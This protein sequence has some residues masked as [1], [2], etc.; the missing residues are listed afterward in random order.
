MSPLLRDP[1]IQP[2]LQHHPSPPCFLKGAPTS[3][4]PTTTRS[5]RPRFQLNPPSSCQ[6]PPPGC[7]LP[8]L[9][10]LF[11]P[12]CLLPGSPGAPPTPARRGLSPGPSSSPSTLSRGG[13]SWPPAPD[14]TW[15][16]LLGTSSRVLLTQAL[17]VPSRPVSPRPPLPSAACLTTH[18]VP[19]TCAHRLHH[20][21]AT[22][23][24]R[25]PYHSHLWT[26]CPLGLRPCLLPGSA[27]TATSGHSRLALCAHT[28][29]PAS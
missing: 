24:T 17:P 16:C 8:E 3:R 4:D 18:P 15:K 14:P 27:G 12:L 13:L 20:S 5:T 6:S 28:A 2:F 10:R 7:P 25:R 11:A 21:C 22:G 19:N 26:P 29:P 23:H 1:W 9:P